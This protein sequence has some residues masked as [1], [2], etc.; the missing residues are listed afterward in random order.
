MFA[1]M[2]NTLKSGEAVNWISLANAN[3]AK[4][5][6]FRKEV[7]VPSGV[8]GA[9]AFL[10]APVADPLLNGYKVWFARSRAALSS[11]LTYFRY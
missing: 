8:T 6:Y 10:T 11:L 9:L 4:F 5:Q 7:S 1:T 3:A 2:L